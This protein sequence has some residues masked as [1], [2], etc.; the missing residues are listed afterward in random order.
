MIFRQYHVRDLPVQANCW[1]SYSA[2]AHVMTLPS[3]GRLTLCP[4]NS[5]FIRRPALLLSYGME[6]PQPSAQTQTVQCEPI[7]TSSA[8][9]G[10]EPYTVVKEQS[11]SVESAR[12]QSPLETTDNDATSRE[13][14]VNK[15]TIVTTS[16]IQI[17]P[18]GRLR[19]GG[20]AV[21]RPSAYT[22][23]VS[24]QVKD[25]YSAELVP[26]L[27]ARDDQAPYSHEQSIKTDKTRC[28]PEIVSSCHL[29][30]DPRY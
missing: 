19:P 22:A 11:P 2:L 21:S 27:S 9:Y 24:S 25:Q 14:H 12:R 26:F 16:D 28:G 23:I 29:A 30:G 18:L 17:N 1:L 15:T 4:C 3:T 10:D 13:G 7:V 6:H 5:L 8:S 20:V